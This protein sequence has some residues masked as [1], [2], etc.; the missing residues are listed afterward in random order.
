MEDPYQ[1]GEAE[2]QNYHPIERKDLKKIHLERILSI[3]H[4]PYYLGA[5]LIGGVIFVSSSI[6]IIHFE[7]S[8]WYVVPTFLLSLLVVQESVIVIWAHGKIKLFKEYLMDIVELPEE[9]IAKWYDAQETII[10]NDK[11]MF[12]T[13]ILITVIVHILGLDYFGFT[14]NRF[15]SYTTIEIDYLLAHYLMGVGLY[16]LFATAIMVLRM[17]KLPLNI[18]I[19]LSKNLKIKGL[20]YSK[21]TIC[22][23]SVYVVWGLFHLSTPIKLSTLQSAIWFSFFAVLL[24]AYFI[25]PQYSIHQMMVKMKEEKIAMLSSKLKPRAEAAFA[26]PTKDNI[27]CLTDLLYF[28]HLLD[29]RCAWPFGSYEILH[30]ALIVIIPFM[31]VFFE[32]IFGIMK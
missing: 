2:L 22:A 16:T 10:F 28:E 14:F 26:N 9:E 32:I 6:I 25:L 29:E 19:F 18:N 13:G 11:R 27:S 12:A 7:N 4:L 20:F 3:I 31:V 23:A 8:I 30:I 15:Y 24:L 1:Y 5:A 17:T 21:F